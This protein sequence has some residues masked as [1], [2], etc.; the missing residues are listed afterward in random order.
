M[1]TLKFTDPRR[2]HR[3]SRNCSGIKKQIHE[4]ST[5]TGIG[6]HAARLSLLD[7]KK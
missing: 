7:G 1:K 2:L 3:I 4:F 5:E 6:I